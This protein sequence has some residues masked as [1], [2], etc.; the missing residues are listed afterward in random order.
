MRLN[1]STPGHRDSGNVEVNP[2]NRTIK[3][4]WG[5]TATAL[6][7]SCFKHGQRGHFQFNCHFMFCIY[8]KAWRATP[9]S[10]KEGLAKI[11]VPVRI[12]GTEV[13]A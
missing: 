7:S 8:R 1:K 11:K 13:T 12:Y 5:Q 6:A 9:R 3:L 10:C 4:G 2:P